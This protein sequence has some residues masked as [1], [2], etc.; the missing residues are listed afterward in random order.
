MQPYT[1]APRLAQA[2]CRLVDIG[3]L[4]H[5]D[6][7]AALAFDLVARAPLAGLTHTERAALALAVATRFKRGVKSDVSERLLEPDM[8]GR[9]R[10]L[11][12][13]MRLAADFSGRS[14]SLLR[15]ARLRCDGRTIELVVDETHAALVSESVQRRLAHAAQELRMTPA[16]RA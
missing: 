9:A 10:A 13:L 15:H 7:R 1:L 16:V 14:A 8:I 6:H 12:S 11:G 4:L 5:P 2:A 3:A